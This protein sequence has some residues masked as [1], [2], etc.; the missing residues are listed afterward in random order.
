M[1]RLAASRAMSTRQECQTKIK[2]T[3]KFNNKCT[4]PFEPKS[5]HI[6]WRGLSFNAARTATKSSEKHLDHF[7]TVPDHFPRGPSR[8]RPAHWNITKHTTHMQPI[9]F[10]A[11]ETLAF[12]HP[13]TCNVTRSP[14]NHITDKSL[15]LD[16]KNSPKTCNSSTLCIVTRSPNNYNTDKSLFLDKRN[17]LKTIITN[18]LLSNYIPSCQLIIKMLQFTLGV[19]KRQKVEVQQ[20]GVDQ[21]SHTTPRS[22]NVMNDATSVRRKRTKKNTEGGSSL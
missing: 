10:L 13:H 20:L 7:K 16:K 9:S 18:T 5:F 15:F 2:Y 21:W 4:P 3:E 11:E 12:T 8:N 19:K 14:N 1:R 22:S 6:F 17:S